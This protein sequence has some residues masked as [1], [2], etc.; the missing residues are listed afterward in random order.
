MSVYEICQVIACVLLTLVIGFQG[1]FLGKRIGRVEEKRRL[2][3]DIGWL[4]G[5]LAIKR[6]NLAMW[7]DAPDADVEEG[8][9]AALEIVKRRLLARLH[10]TWKTDAEAK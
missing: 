4:R 6:F 2:E 3:E 10:G 7:H 5:W 9:I 1:Y 8:E